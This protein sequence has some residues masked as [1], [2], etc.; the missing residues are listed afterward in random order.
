MDAAT[1]DALEAEAKAELWRRKQVWPLLE[2]YLDRDQLADMR[3]FFEGGD[4]ERGILPS[5]D[6][7]DDISRQRGKSWKW[8]TFAVVWAHCHSGQFI[9]YAAQL[10][11]S[12]RNI[13]RPTINRLLADMPRECLAKDE[14]GSLVAIKEDR[15]DHKWLFP[16]G[17]E[18]MAAGANLGHYEDLRGQKSHININDECAFYDDFDAAQRVL[19]PQTQT[20]K[21]VNI[22]AST[23]AEAPSHPSVVVKQALKA[24]GRYVHR[25]IYNHPRMAPEEV[26]AYLRKEAAS[27]GLTLEAFKRTTYYRREFLCMDVTEETR[28]V[29]S[30]WNE[31]MEGDEGKTLGD[32]LTVELQRPEC[33]DTYDG[34]DF[35]YTRDPHAAV[36]GW[37]DFTGGYFYVED[38]VPP[39]FRTRTDALAEA[40]LAKRRAL[41]PASGPAPYPEAEAS[42]DGTFWRPYNSTSDGGGRGTE[43]IWE[44]AKHGLH[45]NAATKAELEVMVNEVRRMVAAGQLRVH[46]RC[47]H[48]RQQLATTLW[49][50]TTRVDFERTAEGHGDALMALVYTVRGVDRS[51]NPF[52]RVALPFGLTR[53]VHKPRETE[54]HR[55][56]KALGLR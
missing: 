24:R 32:I 50:D 36:L 18:I 27:K 53:S 26:D 41:W 48:L 6:W 42:E 49:A 55:L 34:A 47:K 1:L 19:R 35:G 39:L 3:A 11:K 12:V 33:A 51:R 31:P 43:T 56:A 14:P 5:D 29:V 54:T 16:N 13:I 9:K 40:W 20:T 4:A 30:E 25:T 22:Y 46:P 7:Y 21:G 8:C 45:T 15:A 38:E 52:P 44:L 10:G 37:W 28:A 17:S 2:L 23:P